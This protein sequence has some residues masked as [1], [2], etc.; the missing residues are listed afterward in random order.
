MKTFVKKLLPATAALLAAG[1]SSSAFA[2]SI[3]GKVD[4]VDLRSGN[5]NA[6]SS[7]IYIAPKTTLPTFRWLVVNR[8]DRCDNLASDA[9]GDNSTVIF[10]GSGT[11]STTGTVR[12]CPN[13]VTRCLSYRNR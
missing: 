2:W 4:I 9:L 3:E 7:F 6:T 13:V 5:Y 12:R 1:I 10:Q 8:L 11:C